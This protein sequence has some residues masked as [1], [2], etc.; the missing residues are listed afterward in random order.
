VSVINVSVAYYVH[1]F[2]HF[3]T[4]HLREHVKKHRILHYVPVVCRESILTALIEY[5]VEFVAGD[6][7]CHRIRARVEMHLVQVLKIV[8]IGENT[9]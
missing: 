7:E 2:A 8:N 3:E 6:V 9:A 1:E 4:A 5:S